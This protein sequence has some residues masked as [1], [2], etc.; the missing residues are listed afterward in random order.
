MFSGCT[1]LTEAPELFATT[2]AQS[3]Y[4]SMFYNC[5]SLTKAPKLPV[6]TLSN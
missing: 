3:C 4:G 5:T 6:T 2:L 1:S